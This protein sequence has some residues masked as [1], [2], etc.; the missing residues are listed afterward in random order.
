[1]GTYGRRNTGPAVASGVT[2]TNATNLRVTVFGPIPEH[3]WAHT[4]GM[5]IGTE[6]GGTIQVRGHLYAPDAAGNPLTLLASTAQ[7]AQSNAY[8]YSTTPYADISGQLTTIA[9]LG[10][11]RIYG[12]GFAATGS[13][14]H[15]QTA[16]GTL[17]YKRSVPSTGPWNPMGYQSSSPEGMIDTYVLYD[18]NVAPSIPGSL[19]PVGQIIDQTPTFTGTF[20]DTNET[21][22][23]RDNT[24]TATSGEK[25]KQVHIQLRAVGSSTLLWDSIYSVASEFQT[26]RIFSNEY[27]GSGSLTP[28]TPHEWRAQVSDQFDAW[29]AWSGAQ[30]WTQFTINPGGSLSTPTGGGKRTS[31]QPTTF[32]ATWT[33]IAGLSQDAYNPQILQ[34]GTVVRDFGT[35]LSGTLAS[36]T[37]YNVLGQLSDWTSTG[38]AQLD[39]GQSYTLR[40]RGRDTSGVWSPFSRQVAFT[41]NYPPTTPVPTAPASGAVSSTRP[42]LQF[43]MTDADNTPAN[44]LVASVRIKNGAGTVLFTRAATFVSGTTWQYQTTA[45]DLATYADYRWD[46]IGTDGVLTTLYSPERTF[47]YAEGPVITITAPTP[48]R[49]ETTSTLVVSWTAANQARWEAH[50]YRV[51]SATDVAGYGGTGTTQAFGLGLGTLANNTD[52]EVG[53]VVVNTAGLIGNSARVPFRLQYLPAPAI[54]GVS[55]SPDRAVGDHDPSVIRVTWNQSGLVSGFAGYDVVRTPASGGAAVVMTPDGISA[56]SQTAWIDPE[57]ANETDYVY[58]VVQHQA[59]GVSTVDSIVALS[60]SVRVSFHA[61]IISDAADPGRRVVLPYVREPERTYRDDRKT[62]DPWSGGPSV[63]LVGGAESQSIR[64][65]YNLIADPEVE[66]AAIR[67][68][69]GTGDDQDATLLVYRNPKGLRVAGSIHDLSAREYRNRIDVQFTFQELRS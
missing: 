63:E 42:L 44:G 64:G 30:G 28:G 22:D 47:T 14:R 43:T 1:M 18:A 2:N 62:L 57:P 11:G 69:R 33:H 12:V 60:G 27:A 67:A 56:I 7:I 21:V 35:I 8:T 19:A 20:R 26:A 51:G 16:D 24:A 55:A 59:V 41:T 25:I 10:S 46:A 48:G 9:R 54:T 32:P 17:M 66:L 3:C 37:T 45:T 23:G 29:S 40:A 4:W 68:L 61:V 58:G 15:G 39:W 52:Y 50:I 49:V 53:I 65:T 31:R 36:G 38:T 6:A 13:A 5:R 34:N